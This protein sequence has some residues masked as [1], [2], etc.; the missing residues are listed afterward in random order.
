MDM[1]EN[2]CVFVGGGE[3]M[4][5]SFDV[6]AMHAAEELIWSLR[7]NIGLPQVANMQSFFFPAK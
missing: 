3:K 2:A 1:K 7:L 5:I 4:N 6:I